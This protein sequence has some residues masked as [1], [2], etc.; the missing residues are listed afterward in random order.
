M[1][2][3]LVDIDDKQG[4]IDA[5]DR[6]VIEGPLR[7]TMGLRARERCSRAL[8]PR[9]IGRAMAWSVPTSDAGFQGSQSDRGL[10]DRTWPDDTV[11]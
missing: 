11:D 1:T 6:L 7:E 10:K 4:M 9:S 2:G 8:H 3:F 5:V